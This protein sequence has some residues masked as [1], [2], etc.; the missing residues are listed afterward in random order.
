L[1]TQVDTS[2]ARKYGGTGLGLAL[3]RRLCQM[4]GGDIQVQSELGKG[5]RFSIW[6]PQPPRV[7]RDLPVESRPPAVA[8]IVPMSLPMSVE[9]HV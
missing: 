4:M 1:F 7:P 9:G 8:L 2:T 3:S 6:L 5:S